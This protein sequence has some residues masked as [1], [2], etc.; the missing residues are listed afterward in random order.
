M[1]ICGILRV[2]RSG[3]IGIR[4]RL[5][6]VYRKICGFKSHLRHSAIPPQC[7]V[8]LFCTN[9]KIGD[10]GIRARLKIVY[11]KICG[12]KSHLRHSAI[13][14]QCGVCLFCT[15]LKIGD[16]ACIELHA[17]ACARLKI[18]YLWYAGST[19]ASGTLQF[20]HEWRLSILHQSKDWRHGG[21]K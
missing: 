12:F 7:G 17:A 1:S 19:P 4:A 5:K 15:N 21:A 20:R 9:L 8:C 18:V 13:P 11:R 10:T 14:P 3:G 2:S 6:I 16:T